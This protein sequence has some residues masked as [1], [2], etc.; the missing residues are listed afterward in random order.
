M[1]SFALKNFIRIPFVFLAISSVAIFSS[2]Q[3]TSKSQSPD[4]LSEVAITRIG[5]SKSP[6]N[7]QTKLFPSDLEVVKE[8]SFSL[9]STT[10]VSEIDC[11]APVKGRF[12]T[13]C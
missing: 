10:A 13:K 1:Y 8:L 7:V 3:I 4:Q 12:Y 11:Q 6:L 5:N 2:I 9:E